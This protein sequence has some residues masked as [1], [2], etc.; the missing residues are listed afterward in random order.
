MEIVMNNNPQMPVVAREVWAKAKIED[1]FY[2]EWQKRADATDFDLKLLLDDRYSRAVVFK[3][4]LSK[5]PI[6]RALLDALLE[7]GGLLSYWEASDEAVKSLTNGDFNLLAMKE[8][9]HIL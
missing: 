5:L 3:Y 7:D 6:R 1:F 4:L 9:Y 2:S 8:G